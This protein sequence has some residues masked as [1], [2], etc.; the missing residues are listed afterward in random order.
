MKFFFLAILLVLCAPNEYVVTKVDYTLWEEGIG[1]IWLRQDNTMYKVLVE[2]HNRLSENLP[3]PQDTIVVAL[4]NF[5]YRECELEGDVQ[6]H[7]STNYP[8]CWT[9]MKNVVC[10]DTDSTFLYYILSED[11]LERVKRNY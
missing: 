5:T 3:D 10:P 6:W 2:K 9:D 11:Q 8:R 4:E 1:V 7:P